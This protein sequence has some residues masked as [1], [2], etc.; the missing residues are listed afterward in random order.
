MRTPLPVRQL[1][2]ICF[3][4]MLSVPDFVYAQQKVSLD[5]PS[6]NLS[7]ALYHYTLQS[8]QQL[9]FDGH[10]IQDLKSR[11]VKG[12]YTPQ[13]G[14]RQ[15]LGG[16]G[17]K[18]RGRGSGILVLYTPSE[19]E[20]APVASPPAPVTPPLAD[21][22]LT[23][24]IV[25]ATKR[26]R[27]IQNIPMAV[28]QMKPRLLEMSGADQVEDLSKVLPA[29]TVIQGDSPANSALS[30]RGI[31]TVA[32]SIAVE[33][34][35]LVQVD[36]VA[37]TFQARS[38]ADLH[39]IQRIEVLRGPQ[40]MLYGKSS[41][42]GTI[43]ILTNM[44]TRTLKVSGSSLITSD[45]E[46]RTS[47]QVSG[48]LTPKLFY[49]LSL[50]AG[51]YAGPSKNLYT[52]KNVNGYQNRGLRAKLLWK[53]DDNTSALLSLWQND[54]RSDCCAYSYATAPPVVRL[55]PDMGPVSE[56]ASV[57]LEGIEP[58]LTNRR[59]RQDTTALANI[60]DRGVSVKVEHD[61]ADGYKLTSIS[62]LTAF[63]M[64]DRIDSDAGLI[65]NYAARQIAAGQLTQADYDRLLTIEPRFA[66]YA[67]QGNVQ[68][69]TFRA[70][71]RSQELRVLSPPD[72]VRY[73]VGLFVSEQENSLERA[74]GPAFIQQ[75]WNAVSVTK[76]TDIFGQVD[77]YVTPWTSVSGGSR[78]QFRNASYSFDDRLAGQ[79]YKGQ[80]SESAA[81]YRLS[82]Q[83]RLWREN[84]AYFAVATGHKGKAYD[85]SSG[86][87]KA[88]ADRGPVNPET[89]QS[90]E[91]GWRSRINED[92]MFLNV[93][94]FRVDYTDFQSQAI[95]YASSTFFLA[96][97]GK[98]RTQGIEFETSG[99]IAPHWRGTFSA[100]Y[101]DAKIVRYDGAVCYP[102]QTQAAGCFGVPGRQNL[103]NRPLPNAP[104]WK[105]S[106]VTD[107]NFNPDPQHHLAVGMAYRW[108]S[109][110][111]MAMNQDPEAYQEAF[112]ILNLSATLI[113]RSQKY[114]LTA[115]VNNVFD[116]F[117][118][119]ARESGG[120]TDPV[121]VI[122]LPARDAGRYFGLKLTFNY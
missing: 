22:G 113:N 28:S 91:V 46:Y 95:D 19:L 66:H 50:S 1:G 4:I 97:V 90:F 29:L 47:L 57:F 92:R 81:V 35:V 108:Q 48:P 36:D 41:T 51:E 30:M 11:T 56:A 76:D 37:A 87:D 33:P 96:N 38:F 83:H 98:V 10:K 40:N 122:Q 73:M 86:F 3:G 18:F 120:R 77:W 111:V 64:D 43:N 80:S 74:R 14:L 102:D 121:S 53:P 63:R 45:E 54:N 84:M 61:F 15:L 25:T 70:S 107:Y 55:N 13:E 106:L 78:L 67:A 110:T 68:F 7:A 85:L 32:F 116:R 105:F 42:A 88:R 5:I 82:L 16:T 59:L 71:T 115:F 114:A 39:D 17:L 26:P 62:S 72:E 20:R 99:L 60:D 8:G 49:R 89:S 101:L 27:N 94:A 117:F 69:G 100:H 44:P 65:Q 118:V 58:S 23:E 109:G 2:I 75:R 12:L 103:A 9:A 52:G 6:Q 119:S 79:V 34:S 112:G 104:R 31:G 21:D 93:S 24:V